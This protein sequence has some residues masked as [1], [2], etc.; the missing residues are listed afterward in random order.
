MPDCPVPE[1]K[2]GTGMLQ[3]R[4]EMLDARI[5]M[6]AA[7]ASMPMPSNDNRG[8]KICNISEVNLNKFLSCDKLLSMG[9]KERTILKG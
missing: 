6:P 2:S 1:Y 3:E 7:S 4:T 8:P 9:L 5:V